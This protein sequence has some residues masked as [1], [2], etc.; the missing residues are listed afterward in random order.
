MKKGNF[1]NMCLCNNQLKT[2]DRQT[3]KPFSLIYGNIYTSTTYIKYTKKKSLFGKLRVYKEGKQVF[4]P[5]L[6]FLHCFPE[7]STC[8]RLFRDVK[9]KQR[10]KNE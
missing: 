3:N 9:T 10:G 1:H 7:M 5:F 6:S 2:T 8:F 4:S